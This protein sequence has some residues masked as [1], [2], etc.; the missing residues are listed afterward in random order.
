MEELEDIDKSQSFSAKLVY[1]VN[2]GP[3]IENLE[4]RKQEGVS[5]L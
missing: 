4:G 5:L 1:E 3:V 2:E